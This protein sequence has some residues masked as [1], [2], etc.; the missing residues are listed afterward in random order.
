M[1]LK[2]LEFKGN[3]YLIKLFKSELAEIKKEGHN[4]YG[5]IVKG[6]LKKLNQ[7]VLDKIINRERLPVKV[8][9][10]TNKD[11]YEIPIEYFTDQITTAPSI[12]LDV[13]GSVTDESGDFNTVVKSKLKKVVE[14]LQSII[15]DL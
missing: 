14:I 2:K 1:F 6:T 8:V 12:S 5:V 3:V 13:N 10:N 15:K 7:D 9:F 11:C 4:G